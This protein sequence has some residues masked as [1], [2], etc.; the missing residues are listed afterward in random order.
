MLHNHKYIRIFINSKNIKVRF[1][2]IKVFVVAVFVLRLILLFELW[3]PIFYSKTF[4]LY[5]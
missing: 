2:Y 4:D 1:E 5:R 3:F